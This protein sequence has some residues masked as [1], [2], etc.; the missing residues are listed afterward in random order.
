MADLDIGDLVGDM[1]QAMADVVNTDITLLRGYSKAKAKTI[2]RF[3]KLIAEGYAAG[4]IDEAELEDELDE[5][6]MMVERWIRNLKALANTTIERLIKAV[7]T[8]L[9]GAITTVAA[10]AGVPLPA[11]N[12]AE[13]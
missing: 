11:L 4:E 13:D 3:T 2:A 9:Y 12:L 7:T 8:T 5:L 1:A 6:D 10:A